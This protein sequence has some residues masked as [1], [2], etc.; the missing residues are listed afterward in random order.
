MEMPM[1]K[2]DHEAALSEERRR[3]GMAESA[4]RA[5]ICG[6]VRWIRAGNGYRVGYFG[7]ALCHGGI[8]IVEF[9]PKGQSASYSIETL[10]DWRATM[11]RM[12]SMGV[13][14]D[15]LPLA[16]VAEEIALLRSNLY[17]KAS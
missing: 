7:L 6:D 13:G 5:T 10:D 17:A 14:E 8:V 16:R 4:L 15:Y 2:R 9:H 1:T 3:T 12:A 11:N